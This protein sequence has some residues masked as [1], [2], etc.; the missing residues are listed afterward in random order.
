MRREIVVPVPHR[1]IKGRRRFIQ[2]RHV[3][4]AAAWVAS[5]RV[6]PPRTG[7]RAT[8]RRRGSRRSTRAHE[9]TSTMGS[10]WARRFG[11]RPP[12]SPA[13]RPT[14]SRPGSPWPERPRPRVSVGQVAG[15][16]ITRT[17]AELAQV[18]GDLSRA[19]IEFGPGHYTVPVVLGHLDHGDA[20]GWSMGE[21]L[22]DVVQRA[23]E[24][25]RR[26]PASMTPEASAGPGARLPAM[27]LSSHT[28]GGPRTRRRCRPTTARGC[29]W[30]AERT[31]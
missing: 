6:G 22:V 21:D 4:D 11:R 8:D 12:R 16:P 20:A 27:L 28:T 19:S 9:H 23:S 3:E 24:G 10:S 1:H 5:G 29:S 14:R 31:S 17:D 18:S 7:G 13:H 25:T 26:P 15:D 30:S 2:P